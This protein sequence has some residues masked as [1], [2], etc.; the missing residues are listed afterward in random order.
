MYCVSDIIYS[1]PLPILPH[2][3]GNFSSPFFTDIQMM[4]I[5]ISQSLALYFNAIRN[6]KWPP[7]KQCGT[8]MRI[9]SN[10]VFCT[11]L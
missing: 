3:A 5:T 10:A 1:N 4:P 7:E 6:S 2:S 8:S 11:L 9:N